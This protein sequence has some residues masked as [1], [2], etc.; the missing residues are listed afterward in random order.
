[1][2]KLS[3]LLLLIVLFGALYVSASAEDFSSYFTATFNKSPKFYT[4]PGTNYLRAGNGKAQ[5]GGG[6]HA[7][8]Y[9][10]EGNWLLL[11]YETASGNYRIGYFETK[12][13]ANMTVKSGYYNLR[14]MYF[15]YRSATI[16]S[17]CDITD[18]PIMKHASFGR[19]NSGAGCT[20]LASYDSS[21]AYIEANV[22]GKKARGFVPS[23]CVSYGSSSNPG[24]SYPS[25]PSYPSNPTYPNTSGVTARLLMRLSTRSGPSTRY[26]EPGTF[27]NSS[28]QSQTVRVLGKSWDSRNDIWW[29]LVDFSSG[30]TRYRAWTGLKRVN[31]NINSIPEIYSIGE[32]TISATDTW[33]GPG[34]N[35]AK[36]PRVN[37]WKDVV[38]FSRENGYVEVEYYNPSN[39]RIYRC[40]V[41]EYNAQISYH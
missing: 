15:E 41:P 34:S 40:W 5:Y 36:G 4:G 10:Y 20:Y 25:Y 21:W 14:P 17:A 29:V 37:S 28:W 3:V 31:V 33:R 9:G 38:A 8:V 6:G 11:G 12:Y 19:L 16:T 24:Y 35:Y 22:G 18:D 27:F 23:W 1:M 39:D 7:R 2:K 26:D 32:G 30:G 13:T